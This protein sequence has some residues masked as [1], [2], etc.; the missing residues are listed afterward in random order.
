MKRLIAIATLLFLG[1]TTSSA[2]LDPGSYREKDL[3][4]VY[5]IHVDGTRGSGGAVYVPARG[6]K[7][8]GVDVWQWRAKPWTRPFTLVRE[9]P[10]K[11]RPLL[12]KGAEQEI[13]EGGAL[14][15]TAVPSAW[16]PY[17]WIV[18][19]R[20]GRVVAYVYRSPDRLDWWGVTKRAWL[21]DRL[22]FAPAK[23]VLASAQVRTSRLTPR[24]LPPGS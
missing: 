15:P 8:F 4:T 5:R 20:V 14:R 24:L 18:R 1:A 6:H 16:L 22:H 23:G 13:F 19:D 11:R 12:S 21:P 3:Q 10:V 7:E 9:G 17:N 2:Q